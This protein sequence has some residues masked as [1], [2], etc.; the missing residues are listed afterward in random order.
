MTVVT[1]G[2]LADRGLD[3]SERA[4]V[5]TNRAG[6]RF[7]MTSMPVARAGCKVP[8]SMEMRHGRRLICR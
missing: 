2:S 1:T 7:T 8:G 5:P 3:D 6:M 4:R